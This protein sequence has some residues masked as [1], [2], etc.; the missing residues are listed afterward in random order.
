MAD[1]IVDRPSPAEALAAATSVFV[2]R[3]PDI[4]LENYEMRMYDAS[5]L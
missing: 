2:E 3:Y 1:F 5:M 4:G